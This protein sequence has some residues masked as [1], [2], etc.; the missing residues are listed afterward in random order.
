MNARTR[1]RLA[2]INRK[3]YREVAQEFDR[4]R[5]RP[6]AGWKPLLPHLAT[7]PP[8]PRV[9]DVGCGNGRFARYLMDHIGA[10]QYTGVDYSPEMLHMARERLPDAQLI[11]R[12]LVSEAPPAGPFDLV[13]CFGFLH[14]VPGRAQRLELVRALAQALA[15]GGLLTFVTWRFADFERLSRRIVPW[16]ADLADEV[17]N[18]DFLLD[19][20]RGA[21]ALRYCHHCD[22]AEHRALVDAA[23]LVEIASWCADG[24]D[25]AANRFSLLQRPHQG[26]APEP[27]ACA[28]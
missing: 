21:Y 11:A 17:E 9:L 22:A 27:D 19:W 4:T 12:D 23:G 6:W 15:P 18:N 26:A 13:V 16:P 5:A 2:T 24:P 14:H 20:K 3:F 28:D 1:R 8:Q 25:N 10:I 7:L